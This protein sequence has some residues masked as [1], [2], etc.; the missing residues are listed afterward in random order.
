MAMITSPT[1]GHPQCIPNPNSSQPNPMHC[2]YITFHGPIWAQYGS[3]YSCKITSLSHFSYANQ[4]LL[5]VIAET[6]QRANGISRVL[7]ANTAHN[8]EN[9]IIGWL[10]GEVVVTECLAG[11]KVLGH[12]AWASYM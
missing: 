1:L 11:G 6:A 3:F 12:S 2:C 10:V 4:S 8:L 9:S 5:G 7:A